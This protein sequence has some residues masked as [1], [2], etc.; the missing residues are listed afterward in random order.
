[1]INLMFRLSVSRQWETGD[2]VE[3]LVPIFKRDYSEQHCMT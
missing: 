2:L 3:N 1:M